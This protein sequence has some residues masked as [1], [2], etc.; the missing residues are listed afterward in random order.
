VGKLQ[1]AAGTLSTLGAAGSLL[2]SAFVFSSEDG[3][4][5]QIKIGGLAIYDQRRAAARR[6]RRAAKRG[7]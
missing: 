7:K 6:A 2:A 3:T 1:K 4:L 5:Q